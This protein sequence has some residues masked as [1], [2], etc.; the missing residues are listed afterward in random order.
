MR[1][2][3]SS[4]VSTRTPRRLP[5]AAGAWS[6][7]VSLSGSQ[8]VHLS[9]TPG[10]TATTTTPRTPHD[11]QREAMPESTAV[12]EGFP[13]S[14]DCSTR[15]SGQ[16]QPS[17]HE[18]HAA[19]PKKTDA[20]LESALLGLPGAAQQGPPPREAARQAEPAERGDIFCVRDSVARP[21]PWQTEH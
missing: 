2:R 4:A 18:L 15:C 17:P 13:R 5:E 19:V 7:C 6:F 20:S 9:C 10:T 11:P 12:F 1:R 14:S 8:C 21:W 3:P 16:C